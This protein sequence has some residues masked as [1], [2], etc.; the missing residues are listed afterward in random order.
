MTQTS[1]MSVS[2]QER[3]GK[4]WVRFEPKLDVQLA[5]LGLLAMDALSLREGQR[6]LD[7]GCGTGA[8]LIEL[9]RRVGEGG[10]VVGVD[11]SPPMLARASERIREAAV[12]AVETLEAD[13]QQYAF[14]P[15]AFDAVFS[16]FG[17]MFFSDSLAAFRNFRQALRPGGRLAFVCWQRYED[18]E[19]CTLPLRAVERALG[20]REAPAVLDPNQPGP[21]HFSDPARL[22]GL[23]QAAGFQS[24]IEPVSPALQFGGGGTLAEVVEF[25]LHIG[26]ASRVVADAELGPLQEAEVRA[27]LSAEFASRWADDGLW[28]RSA[29]LVVS[30][31]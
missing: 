18:N 29:A 5:P 3:A 10:R 11:S 12:A 15:Q 4:S 9:A 24:Q 21:F 31:W 22:T 23:L 2:F 1:K 19:W 17:V 7:V 28:L 26:P 8:T 20:R 14:Q 27:S 16:R 30:A 6:V 13:A 25:A